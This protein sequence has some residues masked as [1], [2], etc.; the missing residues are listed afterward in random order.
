MLFED[1]ATPFQHDTEAFYNP[2]IQKV[3]VTIEGVLNQLYSQALEP[4][5]SG[6]R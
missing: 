3:E 4:T 2:K 1:P 5:S 6:T